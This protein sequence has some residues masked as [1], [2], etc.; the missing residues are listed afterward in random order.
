MSSAAAEV[1]AWTRRRSPIARAAV[2]VSKRRGPRVGRSVAAAHPRARNALNVA[3][4]TTWRTHRRHPAAATEWKVHRMS[5]VAV[6]RRV[7]SAPI[8]HRVKRADVAV[9]AISSRHHSHLAAGATCR[10][11]PPKSDVGAR[12]RVRSAPVA[13][14]GMI[15]SNVAEDGM[16]MSRPLRHPRAVESF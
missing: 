11:H 14:R 5:G 7:T 4:R 1:E 2:A 3:A 6:R 9:D 8:A 15:A 10:T 13:R 16:L 12:L